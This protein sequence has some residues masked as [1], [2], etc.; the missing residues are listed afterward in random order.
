MKTT[1]LRAAMLSLV[2]GTAFVTPV[3]P[4]EARPPYCVQQAW[5]YADSK[6]D[7]DR[8][9]DAWDYYNTLFQDY[10]QCNT[11]WACNDRDIACVAPE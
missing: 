1:A 5:N 11:E 8:F 4:A 9:S 10:N 2:A 3:A 6:T 7:G